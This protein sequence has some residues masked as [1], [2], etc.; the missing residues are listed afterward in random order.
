MSGAERITYLARRHPSFAS[1]EEWMPRWRAH[2]AL[3]AAQPESSTVRRYAQCEVLV[4]AA[5]PPRDA[6]AF[7]EYVSPEERVRNRSAE[8]YHA[9]MRADELEVFDRPIAECSFLGIHRLLAGAG[10]GPIKVVRFLRRPPRGDPADAVWADRAARVMEATEGVLGYAQTRA[11][12]APGSGW[13]LPVDGCEELWV[14]DVVA[15]G[16]L[17]AEPSRE[18]D[19]FVVTDAVVTAE[20]VL[21]GG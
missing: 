11:L 8:R 5:D 19:G 3:A 1:H 20:V 21:T 4:D 16:R 15:G 18:D 2:W 10:R 6:V 9:V 12:P 7:A 17:L 13:G 14:A